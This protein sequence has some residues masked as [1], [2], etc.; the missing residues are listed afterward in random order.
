LSLIAHIPVI[1]VTVLML[2]L[3]LGEGRLSK[4]AFICG[5]VSVGL[6]QIAANFL[7]ASIIS[8]VTAII[9]TQLAVAP[10]KPVQLRNA[11]AVLRRRWWPFLRTG[12]RVSLLIMLGFIL[13]VVPGLVLAVRYLLWAPV[14]LMEGLERK[15]ALKRAKA[16][17]GRSWR[18]VIVV[19]LV[20]FLVPVLVGLLLGRLAG[21]SSEVKPSPGVKITAHSSS[22]VNILIIPLMSIVPALLYL[23]MRQLGGESINDVL[24]PIEEVEPVRSQWQRRMRSRL[25]VNTQHKPT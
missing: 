10:L 22:L 25:T 18:S 9:V 4:V 5:L 24:A 1:N 14:V 13:L 12:G 2:L 7:T 3:Q 21:V 8:G 20:Q 15:P 17:A 16:L 6:L 23:K 11:F 19:T